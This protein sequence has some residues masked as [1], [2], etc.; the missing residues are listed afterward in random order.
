MTFFR[1]VSYFPITPK[2][3]SVKKVCIVKIKDPFTINSLDLQKF[4]VKS[5]K[6]QTKHEIK[7]FDNLI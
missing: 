5:P 3:L 7:N 2:K 1:H 6:H 4:N